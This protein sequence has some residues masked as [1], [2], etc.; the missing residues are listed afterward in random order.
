M[1]KQRTKVLEILKERKCHLTADEIFEILKSRGET[2]VFA[3][4]YNSLNYLVDKGYIRKIH[5]DAGGDCYDGNLMIHDHFI[6]KK[7]GGVIDV[8]SLTDKLKSDKIENNHID[9]CETTYFGICAKC[10]KLESGKTK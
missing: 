9:S 5:T 6:C 8:P 4:V 3:T 10:L 2:L 1:T 7:C